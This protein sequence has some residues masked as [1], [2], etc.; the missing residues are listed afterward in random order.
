MHVTRFL[1]LKSV[2]LAAIGVMLAASPGGAEPTASTLFELSLEE[3]MNTEV[4]IGS[5]VGT[6][7]SRAPVSVTTITRE[8]IAI[9]PARNL[10]DLI[11][12]YVPGA[13]WL[14]HLS[15][16]VGLRGLIIDR[17]YKFLLLVNG[18]SMNQKGSQGATLELQDWDLNDIERIEVVRGP[19]SV[20]YGPGAIAGVINVITRSAAT[21]PG[22]IAG[23]A[24]NF[25]Y[26]SSGA[27]GS[28]GY[29]G[30]VARIYAYASIRRT[31]GY[32]DARYFM[33]NSATGE[34]GYLP[35]TG[36]LIR[37]KAD[38]LGHEQ[39]KAF[40]DVAFPD[41]WRFWMR[42]TRSGSPSDG[43]EHTRYMTLADGEL[44]PPRFGGE[45]GYAAVLE[46]A[47]AWTEK[48]SLDTTLAYTWQGYTDYLIT[49]PAKAYDTDPFQGTPSGNVVYDFEESR[50][51]ARTMA[52][53]HA[54]DCARLAL[55]YAL[56]YDMYRPGDSDRMFMNLK[57]FETPDGRSIQALMDDGFDAATHT[58]MGEAYLTLHPRAELLLSGRID[59]NDYTETLYSPR[60]AI[61][62]PLN[63]RNII[64]LVWQR[65]VR[66]NTGE[67]LYKDHL[68]GRDGDT[69]TLDGYELIYSCVP[70]PDITFNG[71]V[72]L[73]QIKAIGWIGDQSKPLGDLDLAG[74]ELDVRYQVGKLTL[75]MNHAFIKQLDWTSGEG[76]GKQGI[77]AA[78][79]DDSGLTSQGN[80]LSNWSSQIS[81]CFVTARLLPRV[82][83]H[84]DMQVF[85]KWEG[86]GDYMAMYDRKYAGDD[87]GGRW[88]DLR[89]RLDSADYGD[90]D[91]RLNLAIAWQM[92]VALQP[93]LTLFA[94][95]VFGARRY[96]YSSGV[97]KAYPE[98]ISWVEEPTVVG[99]QAEMVF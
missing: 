80:D 3:L 38:S 1:A 95:N 86:A 42:F 57:T 87:D 14:N 71:T 84:A 35:E 33:I 16:K 15:P 74:C 88:S 24:Y 32:P 62:S 64:K 92:P 94:R 46:N 29:T 47:H 54:S 20:T 73:N 41:D 61:V 37:Y 66:M 49:V 23:V 72:F 22:G 82:T 79:Y 75:G 93:R 99:L 13:L 36:N 34:G 91:L 43:L 70:V 18:V 89:Q 58:L 78:D 76:I 63:D 48:L 2:H 83:A 50:I 45:E 81:K 90:T 65:S 11:E 56:E 31:E 4:A 17:N 85:W 26:R 60:M 19:G 44:V 98:K 27:Y 7:L 53:V 51:Y 28:Y 55:G 97:S 96:S 12:I 52:H 59:R 10:A 40:V 5:I 21:A 67:E 25:G 69:E 77:S 30:D 8:Q 68:N 39:T 6:T 9:T